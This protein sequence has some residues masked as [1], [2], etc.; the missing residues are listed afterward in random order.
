[1]P[2]MNNNMRLERANIWVNGGER[3]REEEGGS[4]S[5]CGRVYIYIRVLTY[6][7]VKKTKKSKI[8]I[9]MSY[10]IDLFLSLAEQWFKMLL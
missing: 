9:Y 4:L 6:V 2:C 1:M 8:F 7:F 3:E 10:V 5:E